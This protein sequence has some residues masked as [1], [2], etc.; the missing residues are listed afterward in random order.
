MVNCEEKY[1]RNVIGLIY[2]GKKICWD[3]YGEICKQTIIEWEKVHG[4]AL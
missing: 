4:G 2:L 3:H 1:C